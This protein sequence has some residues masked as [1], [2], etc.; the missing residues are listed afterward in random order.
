MRRLSVMPCVISVL[1]VYGCGRASREGLAGGEGSEGAAAWQGTIL[2]H[3]L[4]SRRMC[5]TGW[6]LARAF[7]YA[8][9]SIPVRG[10]RGTNHTVKL[11]QTRVTGTRHPQC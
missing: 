5:R 4:V 7:P 9:D 8:M 11:L 3:V 1:V 6:W 2:E 10:A